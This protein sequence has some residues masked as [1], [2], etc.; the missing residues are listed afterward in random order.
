M[1]TE[2]DVIKENIYE[3]IAEINNENVLIAIQTLI[4]NIE[5]NNEDK[6]TS[7]EDF[8]SYI[9]EWVKSM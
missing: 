2:I 1:T 6:V 5:N 3:K 4:E 9:K 8:T 7:K